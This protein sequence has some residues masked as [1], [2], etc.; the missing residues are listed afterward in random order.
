MAAFAL[1]AFAAS[2]A[3][4]ALRGVV[5][6]GGGASSGGGLLLRGSAGQ[7]AV[8]HAEAG[9]LSL[10]SGFW[11]VGIAHATGVGPPGSGT[12]LPRTL[13]I[14][15]PAPNPTRDAT[16]LALALP[17][18]ATVSIAVYDVAGRQIGESRS[19]RLDVGRHAL[20]WSAPSAPAGVY[21][22]RVAVDGE[23][24]AWRRIVLAR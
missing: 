16:R 14:G 3:A 10:C 19:T 20:T 7:S 1:L 5:S 22:A 17:R 24:R 8:G 18:P 23:L 11:C 4:A 2:P 6:S 15:F 12:D 13:A 21:F 9:G